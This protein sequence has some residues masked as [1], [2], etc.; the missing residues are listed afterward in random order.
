MAMVHLL[1]ESGYA[2]HRG[3]G[4][5]FQG[6]RVIRIYWWVIRN[7][8]ADRK[9]W[10]SLLLELRCSYCGGWG[11]GGHGELSGQRFLKYCG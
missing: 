10:L 6:T 1:K 7:N 8:L 9:G 4:L 5:D 11:S 3:H 2:A